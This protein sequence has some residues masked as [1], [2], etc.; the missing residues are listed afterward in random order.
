LILET[1]YNFYFIVTFFVELSQ[2]NKLSGPFGEG[3]LFSINFVIFT[4]FA[5]KLKLKI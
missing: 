1:E 5:I 3:I 4:Q 2:S